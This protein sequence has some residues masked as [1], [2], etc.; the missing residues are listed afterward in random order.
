M[1]DQS[2]RGK[3]DALLS[4]Q[5]KPMLE[6]SSALTLVGAEMLDAKVSEG[7]PFLAQQIAR[8]V[9]NS[10]GA[11]ALLAANGFGIDGLKV[12]R[13]MFESAVTVAYLEK[14]PEL[15]VEY[16]DY[17]WIFRKRYVELREKGG[18]GE[19]GSISGAN[20]AEIESNYLRVKARY[21]DRRGRIR[22]SWSKTS[23]RDMAKAI[24]LDTM[25]D[26]LYPFTSC[27]VHGDIFS[28]IA[29]AGN[30]AQVGL[31]PST[32]LAVQAVRMAVVSYAVT[33][34]A[35][36]GIG[37]FGQNDRVTAAFDEF[38]KATALGEV[39]T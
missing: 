32:S 22:N 5:L 24:G 10:L 23:L 37:G 28:V 38:K 17:A 20:S 27:M 2:A 15:A 35:Y 13:T 18:R 16:I 36:D 8:S 33:L 12:S 26:E 7:L 9:A 39:A 11:V 1:K 30:S 21:E 29:G 25:Y 6:S 3:F 19:R 34:R 31:A 4:I 14:R